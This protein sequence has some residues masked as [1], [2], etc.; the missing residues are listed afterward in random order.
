MSANASTYVEKLLIG[1]D[2]APAAFDLRAQLIGAG[3]ANLNYIRTETGAIAT[4]R[5]RGSLFTDPNS[6]IE[7]AE[8][9]HLYIEHSRYDGLQNAKQ[10][11]RNLIETLQQE[12]MQF[13]QLN[14]PGPPRPPSSGG[15]QSGPGPQQVPQ[16]QPPPPPPSIQYC[17]QQPMQTMQTHT[18]VCGSER[19]EAY[20]FL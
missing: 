9:L 8:P 2:H 20:E 12:L 19:L 5:G 18:Q 14:P 13:Q 3:G 17:Q 16:S 1:L 6:G 10:L 15:Q 7:S 4:L 11:A